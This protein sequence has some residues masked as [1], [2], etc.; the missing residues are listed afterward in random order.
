MDDENHDPFFK[1]IFS[2]LFAAVVL[3]IV[4]LLWASPS[5]STEYSMIP[6]DA[7][8]H[9]DLFAKRSSSTVAGMVQAYG[10]CIRVLPHRLDIPE[11][12]GT[13]PATDKLNA[14]GETWSEACAR[15]Y[16]T[17][18]EATGTVVRRGSPD[19]V[20]CPLVLKDGEW[21]LPE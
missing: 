2:M 3:F 11:A 6:R 9:C 14:A 20:E 12:A 7:I 8:V 21:I 4:V 5:R 13:V 17:W 10:D 16:R 18:D 15:E 19:R 1:W